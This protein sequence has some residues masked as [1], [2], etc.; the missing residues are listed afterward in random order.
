MKKLLL[1]A[2]IF[3]LRQIAFAQNYILQSTGVSAPTGTSNSN[4]YQD[5][6]TGYIG[7]GNASPAVNFDVTGAIGTGISGT[8]APLAPGTWPAIIGAN[9]VYTSSDIPNDA[10]NYY[11]TARRTQVTSL[12]G[13][14][15]GPFYNTHVDFA[16]NNIGQVGI[17]AAPLD[18]AD[19]FIQD[20]TY[21]SCADAGKVVMKI[22]DDGNNPLLLFSNMSSSTIPSGALFIASNSNSTCT[23]APPGETTVEQS[24]TA[25]LVLDQSGVLNNP[26]FGVVGGG[27]VGIGAGSTNDVVAQL[28]VMQNNNLVDFL[29]H[30][31]SYA[32]STSDFLSIANNGYVGIG[33]LN[34]T[35]GLL[36]VSDVNN[37][38]TTGKPQFLID[39]GGSNTFFKIVGTSSGTAVSIGAS[40]A[41]EGQGSGNFANW[42]LSVDGQIVAK[43]VVVTTASWPDTVFSNNYQLKPLADVEAYIQRNHHLPGVPAANEVMQKGISL[44]DVNKMLMQKVEELTLYTINLEKRLKQ[45]EIK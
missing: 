12:L 35:E 26:I 45:L 39:D 30:V 31:G 18:H 20:H 22:V 3:S 32:T 28:D 9:Y 34:R 25:L 38:G 5:P 10:P 21:N 17:G 41:P 2:F 37:I 1:I 7:I 27:V 36:E 16:I 42:T 6:T 11:L 8:T 40:P 19:L 14:G 44:G 23:P 33:T 13:G 29:F 43:E 24:N 15:G 4:I